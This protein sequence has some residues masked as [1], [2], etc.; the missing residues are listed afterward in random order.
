MRRRRQKR[1]KHLVTLG[2]LLIPKTLFCSV[3]RILDQ[4]RGGWTFWWWLD[5]EVKVGEDEEDDGDEWQEDDASWA[6]VTGWC[7]VVAVTDL[8]RWGGE[9]KTLTTPGWD[10]S[11]KPAANVKPIIQLLWGPTQLPGVFHSLTEPWGG[12]WVG[13]CEGLHH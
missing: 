7:G 9:Y 13:G 2:L 11:M 5:P 8:Q 4:L 1:S 12:R 3:C 6:T 10:W